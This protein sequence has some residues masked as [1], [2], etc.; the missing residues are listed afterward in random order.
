MDIRG[1]NRKAW[2]RSVD[3][4]IRW[5]QPVGADTVNRARR[6][7]LE[8]FLTPTK[9]VPIK[10][11]SELTGS[12]ILCLASGGGQQSPV[13]AAA[14]AEVTVFD[15]S[16][17]QLAQDRM[18]AERE[19]LQLNLVE[20]DMA[21]LSAFAGESFDLIFHPCSNAFVPDVSP[22]WQ[23]CFRVLRRGGLLLSGFTNPVRYIF[24]DERKENGNLEV[25]YSIPYSD[26]KD[27][28][29]ADLKT[30]IDSKQPLEF[31]HTL[32]DQIDGQLRAGFVLT[33]FFEDRY[34]EEDADLLSQYLATFMATRA[35]KP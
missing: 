3:E 18:V 26:L 9:P 34:P 24:D 16:P 11:F 13:L 33:G 19:G 25:R 1:H 17:K 29:P 20:G 5:T 15:N 35:L 12:R 28:P 4:G 23:E 10:W 22:V 8:V 6:G 2:D 27:L 21:D 31:G 32:E 14:G 30:I 7:E